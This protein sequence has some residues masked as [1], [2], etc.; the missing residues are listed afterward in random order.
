MN[1]LN[2]N[3]NSEK[4]ICGNIK[5]SI[6]TFLCNVIAR[7][8]HNNQGSKFIKFAYIATM[9]YVVVNFVIKYYWFKIILKSLFGLL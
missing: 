1:Q 8:K 9:Y 6:L 4:L 2:I 3:F 7:V 5:K